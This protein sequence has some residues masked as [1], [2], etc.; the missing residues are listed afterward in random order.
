MNFYNNKPEILENILKDVI[1]WKT[2]LTDK[3][4]AH[5]HCAFVRGL[6]WGIS[7]PKEALAR[8]EEQR[9][10]HLKNLPDMLSHGLD[11]H[12]PETFEEFADSMEESV[13]AFRNEIRP[14]GEIPRELLS[15]PVIASRLNSI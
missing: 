1:E 4:S 2:I 15:L 10:K 3:F 12:S 8:Y 13:N 14:F 5:Y 7:H 11:V 6:V 9:Q